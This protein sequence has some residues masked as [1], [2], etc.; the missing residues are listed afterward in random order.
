MKKS[1]HKQHLIRWWILL[2]VVILAGLPFGYLGRRVYLFTRT[3]NLPTGSGPAGPEVPDRYFNKVWSNANIV[4]IGIGDS[5]TVGFGAQKNHGYFALLKNND[6]EKYPSMTGK[7]L[8]S[9][10]PN[11]ASY[12]YAKNF[13]ITQEH[14]DE[15]LIK[16]PVY[17]VGVKGIVVITSGGNDLI[18]DYG[19]NPPR[20][21]A[22]YGCSYEQGVIWAESLK[23]RLQILLE[24]VMSKFPNGCEIF[25]ANI[26][27]PT[28]GISDPHI[29]GL[30]RWPDAVK[31]LKLVNQKNR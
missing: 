24:G 16:M 8:K 6:D 29:A 11:L 3:M 17:P 15:Q 7:D 1:Q 5:I 31:I 30:P 12:N 25:M 2:L 22:M 21:N 20:D 13:T 27:D 10:L 9:V 19:K 18:H 26:Y 4:L 23:Q 28:D 14:I